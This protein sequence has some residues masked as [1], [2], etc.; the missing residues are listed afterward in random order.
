MRTPRNSRVPGK[1]WWQPFMIIAAI[2]LL[3]WVIS[4]AI[5]IVSL[6]Q[7]VAA[8]VTH[9]ETIA[10]V[11]PNPAT[12]TSPVAGTSATNAP[13][14]STPPS[15]PA[16]TVA[17]VRIGARSNQQAQA[18]SGGLISPGLSERYVSVS[19]SQLSGFPFR[20]PDDLANP[21]A[22]LAEANRNVREQIPDGVWKLN[23]KD[24]ALTGFMLPV[25]LK[26]GLA[27]DFMLL[28]NQLSCCYGVK[29]RLNEW[30]IVHTAGKGVKAVMDTLVT[31]QGTLHVGAQRENGS[32]LG[33]YRIDLDQ[34]KTPNN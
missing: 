1:V 13:F 31:A 8:Q 2:L 6:R 15:A 17:E 21:S 34:L 28:P 12:K 25:R 20:V 33:I 4:P 19:F 26:D 7:M 3:L 27:T 18:H 11:A 16:D 32:L 30:V 5:P 10:P 23:E 14:F 22:D 9:G 24:I 29:P